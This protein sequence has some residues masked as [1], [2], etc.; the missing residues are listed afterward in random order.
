M[1]L[2]R[3]RLRERVDG[4]RVLAEARAHLAEAEPRLERATARGRLREGLLGGGEI[5]GRAPRAAGAELAR[6]GRRDEDRLLV[7]LGSVLVHR[8][9]AAQ[10]SPSRAR[11]AASSGVIRLAA[12]RL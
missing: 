9:A 12:R 4:V 7:G 3:D 1:V 6:R 2:L 11:S 8:L 5:A 10:A